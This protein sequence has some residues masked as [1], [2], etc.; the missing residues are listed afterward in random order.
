MDSSKV[1]LIWKI[2]FVEIFILFILLFFIFKVSIRLSERERLLYAGLGLIMVCVTPIHWV[3]TLYGNLFHTQVVNIIFWMVA[4]FVVQQLSVHSYSNKKIG[5][6]NL[7]AVSV[8]F[9]IFFTQSTFAAVFYVDKESIGGLCSDNNSGKGV[10]KPWCNI[11]KANSILGPGDSVFIRKGIYTDAIEPQKSGTHLKP[12]T[13]KAYSNEHVIIQSRPGEKFVV[14]IGGLDTDWQPKS[15]I[16]VDG[17]QIERGADTLLNTRQPLISIFGRESKHNV[18]RNC[19]LVGTEQPLLSAWDQG[20]GLRVGGI[21]ISKSSNNI[22]ENNI[23]KNM[24]YIGIT[25]GG[26]PKPLFNIIRNNHIKNIVQDGIHIGEAVGNDSILGLLIEG[27]EI[28]GSLISDGIQANGCS[29]DEES[30]DCV[31]VSGVIVRNNKIYNNAE[32]SIDL[33]GTSHWVIEN[34]VL[35]ESYG[36]N[37]GGYKARPFQKCDTPPCNNNGGGS[38]IAKGTNR[39]SRDIIVRNNIIYDGCG[40]VIVSDGYILYNNTI[41]NN[42][43]TYKGPNQPVCAEDS[44]S[45]HPGF[46]GVYGSGSDAIIINNIIG[47]NGFAVNYH[48]QRKWQIDYNLYYS[49]TPEPFKGLVQ[50]FKKNQWFTFNLDDWQQYLKKNDNVSGKDEHSFVG[51]NPDAIFTRVGS[52]PFGSYKKFDFTPVLNAPVVDA[53][54]SLTY[55][56]QDGSGTLLLVQDARFFFDGYGVTEGDMVVIGTN[57]PVRIMHV[58]YISNELHLSEPMSWK[59]GDSV[60]RPFSGTAPDIGAGNLSLR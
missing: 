52:E 60:N 22:I 46:P 56:V 18:I 43:R 47:D 55:A 31:A 27:N 11:A 3:L 33:K 32:N 34:N 16:I 35:Y 15:Y 41:L 5:I 57:P 39:N 42:R 48:Y 50:Y 9:T 12:I 45:R 19:T 29:S 30:K 28:H 53:G 54:R 58:N 21:S 2:N 13:Y 44:C 38:S 26:T 24:T 10:D 49:P 51:K 6:N 36:N 14:N 8:F 59:K 7:I 4:G 17:L 37:D 20:K 1:D 40:G 23:I 25:I